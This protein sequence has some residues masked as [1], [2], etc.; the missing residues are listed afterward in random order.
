[1]MNRVRAC[2]VVIVMIV[3]FPFGMKRHTAVCLYNPRNKFYSHSLIN[4]LSSLIRFYKFRIVAE[5]STKLLNME[6]L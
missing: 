5:F 2:F 6:V 3:V 4:Y 1:M